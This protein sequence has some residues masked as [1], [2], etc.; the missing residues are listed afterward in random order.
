MNYNPYMNFQALPD[1]SAFEFTSES[2]SGAI[3][4]QVRFSGQKDGQVYHL[5]LRDLPAGKKEDQAPIADKGDRDRVLATL[6]QIIEIYTE[7]Y[8]GRIIRLKGNTKQKAQL[9]RESLD[10]H[11][12]VLCP[13]F[14]ITQDE[15]SEMSGSHR[16]DPIAF[17]LKRKPI[18]YLSFHTIQTTWSG[19]SRLF[20]KKLTIEL[21]KGIRIGI[22]M[23]AM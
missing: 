16:T 23:P 9:Y 21:Q 12:S 1:F 18:P 7:R 10:R 20:G 8:P 17:L 14:V 5:D 2:N 19:Q 3:V 15:N 13:L 6:V 11:L 4:R 22:G